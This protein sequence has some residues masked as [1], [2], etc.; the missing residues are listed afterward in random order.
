MVK[1]DTSR[2]ERFI[3]QAVIDDIKRFG[4]DGVTAMID[5]MRRS[6]F[7]EKADLVEIILRQHLSGTVVTN[8]EEG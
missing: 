1:E 7:S 2:V 8:Q 6:G 3:R 5:D 4:V